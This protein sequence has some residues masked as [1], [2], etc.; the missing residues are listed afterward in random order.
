MKITFAIEDYLTTKDQRMA[1]VKS[2]LVHAKL[3]D[4]LKA[5][6][7]SENAR[8][9]ATS[10]VLLTERLGVIRDDASPLDS[11]C[12]AWSKRSGNTTYHRRGVPNW[13]ASRNT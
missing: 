1:A 10:L 7:F 4:H 11:R 8:D 12:C 5:E 9:S 13:E 6:A 3:W 2:L